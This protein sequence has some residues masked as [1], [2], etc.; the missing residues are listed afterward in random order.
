VTI[1]SKTA[2]EVARR[3]GLGLPDAQALAVLLA[4]VPL[5]VSGFQVGALADLATAD[6]QMC[7]LVQVESRAGLAAL[8]EILA[9]E[10]VDG[11]FIGPA[12]LAADMCHGDDTESPA[13]TAAIGDAIDRITA[14]GKAAGILALAPEAAERYRDRGVRFLAVGIDVLMLAGAARATV[15]AWKRCRKND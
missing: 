5:G 14:A 1:D 10:G 6:A 12:D 4:S 3:H 13:V 8:D 7:L 9:V 11:V 2:A 15:E